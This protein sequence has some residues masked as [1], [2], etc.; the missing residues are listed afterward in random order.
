MAAV[1]PGFVSVSSRHA[2]VKLAPLETEIES[3]LAQTWAVPEPVAG[4]GLRPGRRSKRSGRFD[5][6]IGRECRCAGYDLQA[7]QKSPLREMQISI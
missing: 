7:Q 5:Y 6:R 3:G 4:Q 2:V 1:A